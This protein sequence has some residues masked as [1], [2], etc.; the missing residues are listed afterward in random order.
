MGW[1][2]VRK[3]E[4]KLIHK[5]TEIAADKKILLTESQAKNHNLRSEVVV[6]TDP[7][8]NTE[9]CGIEKEWSDYQKSLKAKPT[10][11][12]SKSSSTDTKEKSST[13]A[14]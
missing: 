10:V 4:Q 11:D 1:Y 5:G 3:A 7:P 2:L 8:K 13:K 6:K 12:T 9:E 14:K